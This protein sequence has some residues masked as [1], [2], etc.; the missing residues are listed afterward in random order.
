M[1]NNGTMIAATKEVVIKKGRYELIKT[2]NDIN[3]LIKTQGLKNQPTVQIKDLNILSI[4]WI[5]NRAY[6]NYTFNVNHKVGF[7]EGCDVLLWLIDLFGPM[8]K[9]Y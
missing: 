4:K 2:I 1:L 5:K 8:I 3:C 7:G 6:I 9:L